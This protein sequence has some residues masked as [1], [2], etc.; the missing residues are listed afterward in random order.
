MLK[1]NAAKNVGFKPVNIT[2]TRNLY[3]LGAYIMQLWIYILLLFIINHYQ[4]LN[5]IIF[6]I[7]WFFCSIF[8]SLFLPTW[9]SEMW[10]FLLIKWFGPCIYFFLSANRCKIML[11]CHVFRKISFFSNFCLF[12]HFCACIQWVGACFS[13]YV[14]SHWIDKIQNCLLSIY[15]CI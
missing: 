11:D 8:D 2:F 10:S 14:W 6:I 3:S 5:V 9:L 13:L 15:F 12:D 1:S 7:S 4:D